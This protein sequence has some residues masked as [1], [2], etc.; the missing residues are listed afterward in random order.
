MPAR[1]RPSP[2]Q[3]GMSEHQISTAIEI[4][5]P[6]ER[7][8]QILTDFAAYPAWNPFIRAIEGPIRPGARLTVRIQPSGARAMTFRRRR[9]ADA[10]RRFS[11]STYSVGNSVGNIGK[12]TSSPGR[13]RAMTELS[14]FPARS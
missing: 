1:A 8:W 7:V 6:A 4:E 9:N 10:V 13:Q 12:G 5:A 3:S 14:I 11:L 2:R